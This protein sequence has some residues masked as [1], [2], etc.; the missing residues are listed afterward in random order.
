MKIRGIFNEAELSRRAGLK[1]STVNK[2][3]SGACTNPTLLTLVPLCDVLK[4]P[5][6]LLLNDSF[7]SEVPILAEDNNLITIQSWKTIPLLA[8]ED[9]KKTR[10]YLSAIQPLSWTSTNAPSS[11]STYAL[12]V[13]GDAMA[14]MFPEGSTI[15]VDAQLKPKHK[16]Y[17][18]AYLQD[19][20]EVFFRRFLIDGKDLYLK[21]INPDFKT[22]HIDEAFECLG[23]VIQSQNNFHYN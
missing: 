4:I 22:L 3:L 12:T 9:L 7:P 10:N 1:Q 20:D 8:W 17:I 19:R 21:P 14:P 16:D 18:V 11:E 2:L 23:V 6:D 13:K 15:I 5:V